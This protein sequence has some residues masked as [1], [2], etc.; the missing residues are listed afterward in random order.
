[1]KKWIFLLLAVA[2]IVA[3]WLYVRT[4]R[5]TPEW[6]QPKWGKVDR[7]DIRVPI[8]A[9]GLVEPDERIEIKSKASGEVIK[10]HV[11]EGDFV[12][13]GQVLVE[14]LQ[15]D[16][17]RNVDRARAALDRVTALLAQARVQA[18]QAVLNVDK[19]TANV[20]RLEA[21]GRI[22]RADLTEEKRL[23]E[24][25]ASSERSMITKQAAVD[26]NDADLKAARADL[27]AATNNIE[28]AKAAV[29]TQEANFRE[30]TKTLEEAELRLSETT[31][32]AKGDAIVTEVK[33]GIG[34]LVQSG[35]GAAFG[36]GT[37]LMTVCDTKK[38]MVV[39]RVDE[40][41]YGKVLEIAPLEALPEIP[42]LREAAQANTEQLA[43]RGSPVSITIDA[44]RDRT[45]KGEIERVEPQGKLNQGAAIIQ[46]NVRVRVTDP[47]QHLLP[48]GTQAQVEFTVQSAENV[49]RVPAEAV[50]TYSEQKG[51]WLKV[52]PPPGERWGKRFLPVRFGITDGEFTEVI[53]V[54]GP[55]ELKEGTE[56]YTTRLP[57]STS[58]G[59]N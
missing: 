10:I 49:L 34:T 3:G 47:D 8:S 19:A 56:V 35:V 52:P 43:R 54:V 31:I 18:Q 16:E 46:F 26:I 57:T 41:D 45:F 28:D 59:E 21:S 42:G 48:L 55:G 53:S 51:V 27:Q 14:L 36:G 25:M 6:R 23:M 24:K 33:V 5:F 2:L 7:G 13:K 17:Q 58:E 30:A 29:A 50:K 1:M 11:K 12:R 4:L 20:T 39:T 44:F 40:A 37:V 22:A 38:L 15:I 9:A 32:T